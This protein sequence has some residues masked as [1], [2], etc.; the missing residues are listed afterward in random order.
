MIDH[1]SFAVKNFEE[2]Q[3]FYNETLRPLGYERLINF[4][5]DNNNQVAGYGKNGKPSFWIGAKKV[6]SEK[7][8]L[9]EIGK[10][11]GFHVGFVAPDVNSVHKWY[12]KCL[13]LGG[14]DNGKPGPRPE[15]H[16]GYYGAFIIDP[17][18]WRIEACFQNYQG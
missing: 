4:N 15:Y 12:D 13:E 6:L 8:K 17:N 16:P 18:G 3:N 7:D 2:S 1:I 11:A 14:K 5:H 9:E 10:A